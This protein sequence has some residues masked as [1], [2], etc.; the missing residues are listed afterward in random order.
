METK[1]DDV[2]L[3]QRLIANL[4]IG[5]G[6]GVL[7]FVGAVLTAVGWAVFSGQ[8]EFSLALVL[9]IARPILASRI[10][11]CL[12]DLL[13]HAPVVIAA[14]SVFVLVTVSIWLV[15][16]QGLPVWLY[17]LRVI[18]LFSVMFGLGYTVVL[19]SERLPEWASIIASIAFWG[20]VL[21]VAGALGFSGYSRRAEQN[22]RYLALSEGLFV[23]LL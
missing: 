1:E 9:E 20:I 4:L 13:I 10:S 18:A 15:L 16:R 5:A 6:W 14:L 2:R 23:G 12:T 22:N 3:G 7:L 19:V 11:S 17:L 21:F 8:S